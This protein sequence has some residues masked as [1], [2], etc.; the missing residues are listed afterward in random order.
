MN[1]D[2]RVAWLTERYRN[3]AEAVFRKESDRYLP[4]PVA[5]LDGFILLAALGDPLV[6]NGKLAEGIAMIKRVRSMVYLRNNS[7]FAHGLGPVAHKDYYKFR[8]FVFEIFS[9]F[10]RIEKMDLEEAEKYSSW[11]NPMQ[12]ENYARAIK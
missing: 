5:S 4:S 7:I 8:T 12:S 11:I 3:I 9:L 6:G 10:C 1:Q 2:E